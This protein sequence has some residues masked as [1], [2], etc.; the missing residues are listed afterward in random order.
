M[1][2]DGTYLK[3]FAALFAIINPI[4]AIPVFL[5]VTRD[6]SEPERRRIVTMTT[7][8]VLIVLLVT[9]AFGEGILSFFGIRVAAFQVAGGL[10]ILLMAIAMLQAHASAV[11][12]SE[13]EEQQGIEKDNPAIFPLAIPLV[14]GPGSIATVILYGDR[15][16]GIGDAA[17]MVVIIILI[18]GIVY[19]A[20]RSAV[21]FGTLLGPTGVKVVT[22]L[23]GMLLAA[24]AVE[25]ITGGLT[26][27]LPGLASAGGGS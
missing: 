19:V 20:L 18:S 8:A 25:L 11:H 3:F 10:I 15:V 7:A 22:R 1:L 6:N 16:H 21:R 9:A 23:M 27:L 5:S 17:I 4:G 14:A 12:H 13:S 26:T 24:I 2:E